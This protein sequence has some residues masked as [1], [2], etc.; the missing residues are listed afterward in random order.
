MLALFVICMEAVPKT[1]SESEIKDQQQQPRTLDLSQPPRLSLTWFEQKSVKDSDALSGGALLF[2]GLAGLLQ[3]H[4]YT[5]QLW[6]DF[7]DNLKFRIYLD[8][9]LQ[10]EILS[11]ESPNAFSFISIHLNV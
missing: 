3:I 11:N 1:C 10:K 5:E 6:G 7:F 9:H 2:F 4:V 8:L